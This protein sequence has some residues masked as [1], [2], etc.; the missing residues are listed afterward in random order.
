MQLIPIKTGFCKADT[1]FALLV[2]CILSNY[3]QGRF[4]RNFLPVLDDR[5][6][7]REIITFA[8]MRLSKRRPLKKSIGRI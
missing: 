4:F 1:K 3:A 6:N 2:P 7:V 8:L 5:N